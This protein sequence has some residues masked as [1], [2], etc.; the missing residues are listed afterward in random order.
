MLGAA[1]GWR[2]EVMNPDYPAAEGQ[3]EQPEKIPN[4]VGLGDHNAAQLLGFVLERTRAHRLD[5]ASQK[6]SEELREMRD[7]KAVEDESAVQTE[8]QATQA[9]LA[10]GMTF[11]V[12]Q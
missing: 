3:P 11:S 9:A 10:G 2:A 12:G 7:K 8:M 6:R 5:L 4:P 1:T